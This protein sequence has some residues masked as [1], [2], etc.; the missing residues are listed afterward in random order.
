MQSPLTYFAEIG[1]GCGDTIRRAL[2]AASVFQLLVFA[3]GFL[4]QRQVRI[5]V[6]PR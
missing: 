2:G 3:L 1:C 6:L 5:R 4:E